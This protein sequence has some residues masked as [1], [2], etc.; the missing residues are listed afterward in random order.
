MDEH[1]KEEILDKY[2][3]FAKEIAIEAGKIMLK[4]FNCNN[5]AY[6]KE[7][8]TIV[9]KADNK[10]NSYLIKRVKEVFP[11]HAVDGEEEK[12]GNSEC[13]WVCDPIDGTC[14]Y[15]NNIPIS[16]FSLALVVN[17]NSL[18]GVVYDPFM[19]NMYSAIKGKGAFLNDKKISVNNIPLNDMRSVSNFDNWPSSPYNMYPVVSEL[20]K[21][22][23]FL[24][25]GSVIRACMCVATGKFNL[26]IF[27][28]TKNK[29]CDIAAVKVIVEEAGGRVSNLYGEEQKYNTDIKG[30]IVSNKLV[31]NE[32]VE[33]VNKIIKNR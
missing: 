9:T 7:D 14:P 19:A 18:I 28:G 4:Y 16:V 15:A 3:L 11:T 13:V 10:I 5:G 31:H 30:A 20:G 33:V 26:A 22:T 29:N 21:K 32:V 1:K 17:G 24:S 2:L 25:L 8:K 6:Y 27:P 12:F 23:Y